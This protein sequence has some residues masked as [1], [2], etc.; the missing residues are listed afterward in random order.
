MAYNNETGMYEGYI[1]IITND[2]NNKVY[3]GQT[4]NTIQIRWNGH[5]HT[6][7]SV[8]NMLISKAIKKYGVEHFAI[9]EIEKIETSNENDLCNILNDKERMYISEYNSV[10]PNGYNLS[11]GG[12]SCYGTKSTVPINAYNINKELLY[13]FDSIEKAS[14]TL[15]I[16]YSSIS[17]II[18]NRTRI[19]DTH[20]LI[21]KR[22]SEDITDD[23]VELFLKYNPYITQYDLEGNI[24]NKFNSITEAYNYLCNIYDGIVIDKEKLHNSISGRRSYAY[25]FIWRRYPDVFSTYHVPDIIDK[26]EYLLIEK[27]NPYNGEL[28]QR[29]NRDDLDKE[30]EKKCVHQIIN[31]CNHINIPKNVNNYYWCYIGEFNQN[32]FCSFDVD[33]YTLRGEYVDSFSDLKEIS[34]QLQ[35]PIYKIREVCDGNINAI[36]GY[37][38]RYK[39]DLFD[40]YNRKQAKPVV[41]YDLDGNELSK[42]ASIKEASQ[43]YNTS[44]SSISQCCRGKR[45]TVNKNF[46]FRFEGDDFDKYNTS[47]TNKK[48]VYQ[49][50]KNKK[51]LKIFDSCAS[52]AK[53]IGIQPIEMSEI[54]YGHS[55]NNTNYIWSYTPIT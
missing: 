35:V 40:K 45:I 4:K 48:S 50:S 18:N 43:Y 31:L 51:L 15:N 28:I 55:Q 9:R 2:I 30:F 24:L 26:S 14:N 34:N 8:C 36:A 13:H 32:Y 19:C 54:C 52:A 11:I 16:S 37:I 10:S 49:Y 27:R 33:R 21:I 20:G 23:D 7:R 39:G 42:H 46:I 29:Y 47:Y 53:S 12:D 3:I 25:G 41:C 17:H 44:S 38:F 1:Y 6:S 5:K 22:A